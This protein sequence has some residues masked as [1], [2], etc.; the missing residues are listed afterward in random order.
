MAFS[1]ICFC[2]TRLLLIARVFQAG[3]CHIF[4]RFYSLAINLDAHVIQ[5]RLHDVGFN[6]SIR[7]IPVFLIPDRYLA[8]S[9]VLF[10]SILVQRFM[11]D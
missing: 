11:C 3:I 10:G 8:R 2:D 9:I 5:I 6:R 1:P 4:A 7:Q